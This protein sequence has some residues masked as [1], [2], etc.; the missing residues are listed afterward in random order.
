MNIRTRDNVVHG[1][2]SVTELLADFQ[3]ET[4]EYRWGIGFPLVVTHVEP[5]CEL[6]SFHYWKYSSFYRSIAV[7]LQK[8]IL[9]E[10]GLHKLAHAGYCVVS[11]IAKFAEVAAGQEKC[12][13]HLV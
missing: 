3:K 4:A 1:T 9:L 8:I 13:I 6:V 10:Y 12:L 5:D 11:W 2:K 7:L